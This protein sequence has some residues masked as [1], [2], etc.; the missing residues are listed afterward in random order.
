MKKSMALFAL[1]CACALVL[2]PAP[3]LA[4]TAFHAANFAHH[5]AHF[6][7]SF[8]HAA[9]SMAVLGGGHLAVEHKDAGDLP[10]DPGK[11]IEQIATSFEEFRKSHDEQIAELKKGVSD[12]VLTERLSKIEKSLEDGSEAKQKIDAAIAAERKERED[13]ELR[14]QREGIKGNGDNAKRELELKTFNRILAGEA[15]ER[16][17]QPVVLDS[18]GYDEY[19][20]AFDAMLRKNEKLLTPDEVKT[21]SVGSDPDGGY[22]VTPDVSGRI[23]KKLY[24][25]SPI[26]Q[27][28][29]VQPISTDALE[30]MEDI[31][32]AGCGYAGEHGT[33]GDGTTPQLGKWRI[34]V[35]IIDTEPKA[36]QQLLDDGM[37]DVEAWLGGK[38][39]N[40]FGRFE[41]SEFVNGAANKIRGF[42]AGYTMALDD[43]TGVTWGQI[44]YVATGVNGDFAATKPAD[45]LHDLIGAVKVDYLP[46]ASFVTRRTVVTKIRKFK[47]ANDRYILQPSLVLGSPDT[48]MGYPLVRAEDMPALGNAS[49]SLAFGDF[50]EAYQIVDRQGERV[51]RDPYTAKPYVKFY[52]TKRVGGGI[53]NYEAIKLLS[54]G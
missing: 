8:M 10:T 4:A 3:A 53:V 39:G 23:A 20:T 6:D 36:T 31:G 19:K 21:L 34:P 43:G 47:D 51:L 32:E 15:A 42:A 33:S 50:R 12:P 49:K 7:V 1:V 16:K 30:G 22:L 18:K 14:L 25:T 48:L 38:V 44:G 11:A 40:K 35:F 5:A 27:L 17:Q 29:S 9:I 52:T 45:K 54:F 28:A 13:L 26:R 24:E 37:I 46:N 2:F 41:N